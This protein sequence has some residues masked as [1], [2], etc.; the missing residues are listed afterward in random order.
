MRSIELFFDLFQFKKQKTIQKT[1]KINYIF[2][3]INREIKLI[4]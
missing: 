2:G 3:R 4:Y 1:N